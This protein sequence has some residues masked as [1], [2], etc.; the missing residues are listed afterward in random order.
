[1]ARGEGKFASDP[2]HALP[3]LKQAITAADEVDSHSIA[4]SLAWQVLARLHAI[5]PGPQTFGDQLCLACGFPPASDGFVHSGEQ[6]RCLRQVADVLMDSGF[7]P[8]ID[9]LKEGADAEVSLALDG[10]L[11]HLRNCEVPTTFDRATAYYYSPASDPGKDGFETGTPP[12]WWLK[13]TLECWSNLL[14]DETESGKTLSIECL[15]SIIPTRRGLPAIVVSDVALRVG[16]SDQYQPEQRASVNREFGKVETWKT[17]DVTLPDC[18]EVVDT[19]VPSH[20]SPLRYSVTADNFGKSTIRV[21]S[22]NSWQPGI[23]AYS[24]TAGKVSVPKALKANK[25]KIG[26]E[27]SLVLSGRGRHYL[28]V[29]VAPNVSV[30]SVVFGS[31]GIPLDEVPA[32]SITKVTDYSYGFEV[33][34]AS[35]SYCDVSF[36]RGRGS[37]IFRILLEAGEMATEGCSSEFERLLRLNRPRASVRSVGS[38]QV[39]RQTRCS[40]LQTWQLEE[41]S[42]GQSYRPIVIGPDYAER[43]GPPDW[44]TCEGTVMSNAKFLYDPRPSPSEMVAPERFVQARQAIAARIRG[45]DASG[46]VEGA[47]LGEWLATDTA[48]TELLVQYLESYSEWLESDPNVASWVDISLAVSIDQDGKTL[49]HDADAVIFS[50]LHP[51]RLIWQAL[52]QRAMYQAIRANLPSPAASILDPSRVPDILT[53]PIKTPAGTLK[54]QVFLALECNSDYWTILWNGARLGSRSDRSQEPPFDR[55][56]GLLV[57]GASGG[58]SVSQIERALDDVTTML[59][60]KPVVSVAI[61]GSALG[62]ISACDEGLMEWCRRHFSETSSEDSDPMDAPPR[63]LGPRLLQVYDYRSASFRPDDAALANIAEDTANSVRWFGGSVRGK[64]PDLGIIAQLDSASPSLEASELRSPLGMGAL[65]RHRVRQQLSSANSAFLSES[66]MG[67]GG[68]P[69]GDGIADRLSSCVVRLENLGITRAY[70]FAPSVHAIQDLLQEKRADFVAVS[71]SAVDPACFL[72]GW[73]DDAYLWDYNL[74]SYSQRAGDTNGYYLLSKVK[75][76]DRD[77]LKSVVLRLPNTESISDQTVEEIILEVARR[78]IPTV[79][80]LSSGDTGASGDLG[81]FI[82]SRLLQDEFRK[83]KERAGLLSSLVEYEDGHDLALVVPVDPFWAHI[84][85]LQRTISREESLRADFLVVAIS[86][87]ASAVRLRLTPIEVKYRNGST[88]SLAQSKEALKQASALSAVLAAIRERGQKS[89]LH[90]WQL[91][92]QHLL[93]SIVSYGFRVY[94]QHVM[95]AA[96]SRLWAQHHQRVIGAILADEIELDIDASGRLIVLDS[97]NYSGPKDYDGDGFAESITISPQD[98]AKIMV[99]D[100]AALYAGLKS[101]LGQWRLMPSRMVLTKIAIQPTTQPAQPPEEVKGFPTIVQPEPGG[102]VIVEPTPATGATRK[103]ATPPTEESVTKPTPKLDTGIELS[104]GT[105]EGSFQKQERCLNLSDTVLNQLNIGVVGDLGTGKTQF[106][107]SLIY[108][109]E[110][111]Q[112][113]NAGVKPRFLIFDYKRD[114]NT[115]PFADIAGVRIVSPFQLPLNLFDTSTSTDRNARLN[116]YKFFSDVLDKI[117]SGIGPVQRAYLKQAI[118]AAFENCARANRQPTIY[119][120]HTEYKNQIGTKLDS[121][122]SILDDLV[123]AEIF[124]REPP[125]SGKVDEFLDGAV[126]IQLD[127][128]GQDDRTKNMLVAVMLNIF[129]EHMLRIPKRPYRGKSPQLRT[130]DSFLL[131]DEADSIMRYEFDVLRKILLQGREF[132]VGVILASQYLSH[133]KAGATDYR[134]PLLTWFVHKVPNVTPQE[135]SALGLTSGLPELVERVKSLPNHYCLYKTV[136]VNGDIIRGRPFY[137]LVEDQNLGGGT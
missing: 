62:Q 17:W 75:D 124:A 4:R 123:D 84:G 100:T 115:Q 103:P 49:T 44:T 130:I 57:G 28:D 58:F 39:D 87:T 98:A 112:S 8:G 73:L 61:T 111:G 114:Y 29:F 9:R 14:E 40:Q 72:G 71:S 136:G 18:V 13:L 54:Q 92:F 68:P 64:K 85:E 127:A 63:T 76:V 69:T 86:L 50:P 6:I 20:R 32:V 47:P 55:E 30:A 59:A 97:S 121:V 66:R 36:D 43:W 10:C 133:F 41:T 42:A 11:A 91:T 105:L 7:K 74:P 45:D 129:Y 77:T 116:R 132:G 27:A 23:F 38:V 110:D 82:A 122:Y 104:L 1:L 21:V 131:V 67:L 52:A 134:E 78:G 126:V 37:E 79:R 65:V 15:N 109:I 137:Q 22:L 34:V 35:D 26:F 24:S 113:R 70:T 48:F 31:D 80:G 94:S 5:S 93:S 16:V 119:D 108:Q 90:L 83:S 99:G 106:L 125:G 81:L 60:A 88:L 95:D 135:L 25:E 102:G 128:L 53:V 51:V 56:F 96:N 3:L 107:K 12:S 101:M 19:T 117:Y 89:D 2:E 46:L 33:D 118:M 120:V